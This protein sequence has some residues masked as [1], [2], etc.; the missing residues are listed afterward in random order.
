MNINNHLSN[1][2]KWTEKAYQVWGSSWKITQPK[3]VQ[4]Q[5]QQS[6]QEREEAGTECGPVR[7]P[8]Q[9]QGTYSPS[10]PNHWLQTTPSWIF[11]WD[12]PSAEK[13]HLTQ[14]YVSALA[15]PTSSELHDVGGQVP[16]PCLSW[17]HL[18]RASP[19]SAVSLPSP[20]SQASFFISP[21]TRGE[22]SAHS[23]YRSY[24]QIFHVCFQKTSNYHLTHSQTQ[25]LW[26]HASEE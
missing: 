21:H 9:D 25:S 19:A 8:F 12:L 18:W 24:T 16:A 11:L 17:G 3:K 2:P 26:I 7:S 15:Q 5:G 20:F 6:L 22:S 1:D 10:C 14:G 13:D 23:P 4:G